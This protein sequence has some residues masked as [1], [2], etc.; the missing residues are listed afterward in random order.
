MSQSITKL[1]LVQRLDLVRELV[2]GKKVLHLGCSDYPYTEDAIRARNHLHLQ[3]AEICGK[4][5]GFDFD[6]NGLTI[7]RDR[8][9][10]DLYQA[11]LEKL[12]KVDLD[13]TF[14]I[15]IAGEMIEHLNNPGLFLEGIKRFMNDETLLVVTTVNAYSAMRFFQYFMTRRGGTAEPVHPDH[16]F[17]FSYSTLSL[18]L[19]RHG[20]IVDRFCFY[21]LG[22][23]HR[24]F[25]RRLAKIVNDVS[26]KISPQTADGV[27]A[28]CRLNTGRLNGAE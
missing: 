21:D 15:I 1:D 23:E 10:N 4:L 2:A 7:L 5:Y 19:K 9:F 24:P 22:R 17:Y 26:V 6:E 8:G 11:D 14:D 28:V 3:L 25:A 13:E 20:F 12:D 16:T 27:I 18:L